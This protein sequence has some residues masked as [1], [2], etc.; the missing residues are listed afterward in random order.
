MRRVKEFLLWEEQRWVDRA[1]KVETALDV[2][3]AE[4]QRAYAFRQAS[5]RS[6]MRVYCETTWKDL[7][8]Y[9][10]LGTGLPEGPDGENYHVE[11]H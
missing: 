1:A 10:S 5:I 11:C 3:H 6:Q 2:F 7:P 8:H 4:G 9:M